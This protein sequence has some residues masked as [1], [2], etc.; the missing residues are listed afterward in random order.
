MKIESVSDIADQF[1]GNW[2][3]A[4]E[5]A[6]ELGLKGLNDIEDAIRNAVTERQIAT[7]HDRDGNPIHE[8]AHCDV[9]AVANEFME[10]L[11][12]GK[13]EIVKQFNSEDSFDIWHDD[14][15]N[16]PVEENLTLQDALAIVNDRN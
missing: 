8:L 11:K 10:R 3:T 5:T 1:I 7:A 12:V 15:E 14:F 13:Y 9:V 4:A 6:A 16:R 2:R